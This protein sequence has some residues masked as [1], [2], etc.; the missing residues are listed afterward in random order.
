VGII[1]GDISRLPLG[2]GRIAGQ[3]GRCGDTLV[4]TGQLLEFTKSDIESEEGIL[5]CICN[6]ACIVGGSRLDLEKH[7]RTNDCYNKEGQHQQR[8][9]KSE[10]SILAC[11]G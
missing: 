7:G 8:Q 5:A 11:E 4:G 2:S 10:C 6:L 3:G 9:N 1:R